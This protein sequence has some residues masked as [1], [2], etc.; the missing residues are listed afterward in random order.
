MIVVLMCQGSTQHQGVLEGV[1][2]HNTSSLAMSPEKHDACINSR[3]YTLK[4]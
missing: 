3:T 2:A 4:F 1:F